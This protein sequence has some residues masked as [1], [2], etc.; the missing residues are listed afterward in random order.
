MVMEASGMGYKKATATVGGAGKMQGVTTSTG[1]ASL[2]EC[3]KGDPNC[4][5][6]NSS[7]DPHSV[8]PFEHDLPTAAKDPISQ[9]NISIKRL[10]LL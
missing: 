9:M 8:L 3:P 2:R 1:E 4:H 5:C 10:R 6:F 7:R